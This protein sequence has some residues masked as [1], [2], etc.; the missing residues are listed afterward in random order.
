MRIGFTKAYRK[1][2]NSDIWKMPPLY[3]R[4]FFYLRQTAAWEAESFPT[5]KGYKIAV[6][7]GQIITSFSIIANGVAWYEYGVKRTPNK[8]VIKDILGWLESNS[9]VTVY[10]NRH[11]TFIV[12]TNWD[13]YN[14]T[15]TKEVTQKKRVEVTQKKR[16]VD[17]LKEGLEVKDKKKEP[18][19]F[20]PDS[21][22]IRL[23]ELLFSLMREN[24]PGAKSP[25]F[26]EWGHSIDRAIRLD[27]RTPAEI[28]RIIRWSQAHYFWHTNILST[29]K[30]RK[31]FDTLVLKANAKTTVANPIKNQ[32]KKLYNEN[33]YA[34]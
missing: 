26:Q 9:M 34:D 28:E 25:D 19:T 2:L 23:S 7:P 15:E 16:N 31:Q 18:K 14:D 8:K 12:L 10:S 32:P 11:G 4:V 5:K 22:E 29:A 3:H 13:T 30:L 27:K 24:N 6:N 33:P 21:Q 20:L 17:T 1:E